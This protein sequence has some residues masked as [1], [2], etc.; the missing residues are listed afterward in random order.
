[1]FGLDCAVFGDHFNDT[2]LFSVCCHWH[3]KPF[4]SKVEDELLS[5]KVRGQRFVR[6]AVGV[7]LAI[8][9]CSVGFA[10]ISVLFYDAFFF[11]R[12]RI[13]ESVSEWSP[14]LRLSLSNVKVAKSSVSIRPARQ[15]RVR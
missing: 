1:M 11:E 13:R 2:L 5:Q 15:H 3:T 10:C 9:A 4:A 12:L 14:V 6:G 7:F 8:E